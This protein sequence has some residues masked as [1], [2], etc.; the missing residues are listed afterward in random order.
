VIVSVG[1]EYAGGPSSLT[2]TSSG[3]SVALGPGGGVLSV[4]AVT[5]TSSAAPSATIC[6]MWTEIWT[7][8][9]PCRS[10]SMLLD[11]RP[12]C[13]GGDG[14]GG[15][16]AAPLYVRQAGCAPVEG[17]ATVAGHIV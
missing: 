12:V 4:Q 9:F 1:V 3:T 7:A 11:W 5:M 2:E 13:R 16:T 14:L 17:A 6:R 15:V 10:G 8:R